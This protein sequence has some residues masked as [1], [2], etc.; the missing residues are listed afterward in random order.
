MSPNRNRPAERTLGKGSDYESGT[1]T[2]KVIALPTALKP[3]LVEFDRLTGALVM[4]QHRAGTLPDAV[5]IALLQ[6]VGVRP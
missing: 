4:A 1:T 6:G 5:V 3:Q 2:R